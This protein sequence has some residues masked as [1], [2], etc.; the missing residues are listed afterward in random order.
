[1]SS[2][3]LS[4]LTNE[5]GSPPT[6]T[7]AIVVPRCDPHGRFTIVTFHYSDVSLLYS[8]DTG[9]AAH[10]CA[11]GHTTYDKAKGDCGRTR[12][13]FINSYPGYP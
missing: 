1:M 2:A 11:A 10:S 4:I 9:G 6:E 13:L 7:Q 3:N 12:T 8:D 5:L